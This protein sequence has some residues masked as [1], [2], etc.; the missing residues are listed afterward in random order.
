M[1]RPRLFSDEERKARAKAR[2]ARWYAALSPGRKREICDRSAARRAAL[3][4]EDL[5][6]D[7]ARKAARRVTFNAAR[8]VEWLAER[9][10]ENRLKRQT[11]PAEVKRRDAAM[12]RADRSRQRGAYDDGTMTL[13]ANMA[14]WESATTCPDCGVILTEENRTMDHIVPVTRGGWHSIDNMRVTCDECNRI[15]RDRL[16][17][18]WVVWVSEMRG[19]EQAILSRGSML[20]GNGQLGRGGVPAVDIA[21]L[22]EVA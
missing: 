20:C 15:K 14:M 2:D 8:S 17:G 5:A 4:P 19:Y 9:N 13:D 16:P 12:A 6:A 18:E 1:G 21:Q 11:R 7:K 22:M 3:S 10:E